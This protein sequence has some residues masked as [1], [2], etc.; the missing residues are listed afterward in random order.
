MRE[1]QCSFVG[2]E[3]DGSITAFGFDGVTMQSCKEHSG[4]LMK[5]FSELS[6]L[7]FDEVWERATHD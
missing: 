6:G 7:T 3:K 4:W 5:M 2:C 1:G